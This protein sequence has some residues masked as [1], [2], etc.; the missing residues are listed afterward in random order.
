MLE[1]SITESEL[2]QRQLKQALPSCHLLLVGDKPSFLHA[3]DE[4]EPDLV[5]SDNKLPQY[6]GTEALQEVRSRSRY[7]PFILLTGTVSDEFAAGILKAG[8]DD[9]ILKDRLER[10]PSAISTA[11]RQKQV[12]KELADYRHAL[13]ASSIV[14]ITDQKRQNHICQ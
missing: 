5:L 8:A 2:V 13:D 6:S 11:I 9:Y 10:L 14:A 7:I 12:E 1:D 3:L 4:F